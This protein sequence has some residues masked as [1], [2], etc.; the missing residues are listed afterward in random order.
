MPF[1]RVSEGLRRLC[2]LC[3]SVVKVY[4]CRG[5][6]VAGFEWWA[7]PGGVP[8]RRQIIYGDQLR[9]PV[10]LWPPRGNTVGFLFLLFFSDS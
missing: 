5:S 7:A 2:V 10:V 4:L 3:G 9:S 1:L 6:G 8:L